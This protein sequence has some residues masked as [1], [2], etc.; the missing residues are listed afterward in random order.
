MRR[1]AFLLWLIRRPAIAAAAALLVL[2]FTGQRLFLFARARI[3]PPAPARAAFVPF[4]DDYVPDE[5]LVGLRSSGAG[6]MG[7]A[8]RV[9]GALSATP[10]PGTSVYRLKLPAG[11]AVADAAGALAGMAG[12]EWAEPNYRVF[13]SRTPE[14]PRFAE[15]WGMRN[16]GRAFKSRACGDVTG[17]PGADIGAERAWDVSRG[18]RAVIVGIVDTGID[19]THPNLKENLWTNPGEIPDNGKDD[20]GNGYVDDVHG[21][22]FVNRKGDPRD[23]HGHGTHVAGTIGASGKDGSGVAGVNWEIRLMALKFLDE[24]GMGTVA[25]AAEALA[26]ARSFGVRIT[27][28]SW[29]GGGFNQSLYNEIR[30]SR[31][32]FVAA[33]GNSRTDVDLTPSYPAA[34]DLPNILAVAASDPRDHLG[35]FSNWGQRSVD[36]AAPG[37]AILSTL[38]TYPCTL[39]RVGLKP[40]YDYLDGTSMASPHAAGAVALLLAHQPGESEAQRKHRLIATGRYGERLRG[41]CLGNGCI[42]VRAGLTRRLVPP[43][44]EAGS[45]T[46]APPDFPV[47]LDGAASQPYP[48]RSVASYVWSEAGKVLHRSRHPAFAYRS[49]EKRVHRIE[50]EVVDNEGQAGRDSLEVEIAARV[51]TGAALALERKDART[52]AITL[53]VQDMATQKPVAGAVATVLL[54]DPIGMRFRAIGR[55][56]AQGCFRAEWRPVFGLPPGEYQARLLRLQH[57]RY[58]WDRKQTAGRVRL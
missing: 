56:D 50:L 44:A 5:V 38:P 11:R 53:M 52:L 10:V 37:V 13:A 31:A 51:M 20:D 23:D 41:R 8:A 40:G 36:V 57:D 15:L 34:Y 12:I 17:S 18:S 45:D 7:A 25:G 43:I 55:T 42:D 6:A 47:P 30:R 39:T 9:A 49:N 3:L 29:G 14:G 21:Y 2:A 46:A 54:S 28:N 16:T 26:Y 1:S 32:L 19:T 24:R 58:A 27:N 4:T 48:G 33:A 22:D 35:C